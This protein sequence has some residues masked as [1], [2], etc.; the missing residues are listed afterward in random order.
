V[1][2]KTL[3]ESTQRL[4]ADLVRFQDQQHAKDPV[5][6][7]ARRRYV[8][9]LREA[10]KFLTVKKVQLLILAPDLEKIEATGGLNDSLDELKR[11]AAESECPVVFSLGR[12]KLGKACRRPVAI[13]C[14][15]VLNYH[16][17]NVR[18]FSPA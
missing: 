10:K 18:S 2:S 3:D 15:A 14:V 12:W 16:G 8:V 1:L 7:K 5:K 9:G 6:A 4:L 13:S 17:A 11:L